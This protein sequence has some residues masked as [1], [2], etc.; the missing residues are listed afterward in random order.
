MS[1]NFI[2]TDRNTIYLLPPSI[3]DWLPK[4]HLA[5]FIA[6]IVSQLNLRA[7]TD[8]YGGRGSKAYHPRMLLALLFYGYATG[9]FSSRKIEQA[10]YDSVAFRFIAANNHPDHDTIATFRKRFIGD[11]S[12]LFVQILIIAREMGLL[13][14]GKV[15]LDGTKIKAN[16]SKHRA[17]SWGHAC[18][19]E[20]QLQAEVAELMRLAEDADSADI[21][22]EM[23]IPE[24]L[25]RRQDRLEAIT[26]AKKKIEQRASERYSKEVEEYEQKVADRKAK[27]EQSG[28]KSKGRPPEPPIPG[29]RDKDQVNL[30]DEES[31][32]M[33]S[34]KGFEQAY[35]AQ[36]SVD[37]ETMCIVSAHV[38]QSPNDKQEIVPTIEAF[39]ELPGNLGRINTLLADTGY[40]SES[41]VNECTGAEITPLIST[42]RQKHN[43][44]L[45]ERFAWPERLPDNASSTEVMKHYLKTPEGKQLYGKRKS[46]VEPVFGI[47]K[48]VMG[49]RQFF[50]R[51]FEAVSGEWTL[52]SIAWNLKRM[53]ALNG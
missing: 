53:F 37:L 52:V 49:F 10:T 28:K 3:Q 42:G 32:I 1:T 38:T 45:Q 25:S 22:E 39:E 21:P 41:N 15:S 19:I 6:D 9:V 12:S 48:H 46:T 34:S 11:L 43:Q 33:P 24:E 36:A 26:E 51:G 4:D 7:I 23:N 16:A 5:R 47:I 35:N 20:K 27:A 44:P 8:Q 13:K 30:T 2:P 50:L 29:P 14:L 40:F 31:R 17:L 18:K